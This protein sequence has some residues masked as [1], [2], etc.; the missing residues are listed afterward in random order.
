MAEGVLLMSVK[1]RDRVFLV[2]QTV[3]GRLGQRE[4]SERLGVN[5]RKF[6]RLV[7][8]WRLEGDAGLVSRHRGWSSNGRMGQE[9][10]ER[11]ADLLRDARY[12]GF[13]ASLMAETLELER[14]EVSAETI[15]QMRIALSLW[16]PKTRRARRVFQP[17]ERRPRFGE[18]IQVDGSP[19]DW[20][21]GRGPRCT[22]IVFIDD[23][24]NRLT[25]LRFAP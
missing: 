22:L 25:A 11:I 10:R 13:G 6:K 9:R 8:A 5:V 24:T 16:K 14:I 15:R 20:F 1:E 7:R 4:A 3:E 19:H 23:A 2:R 12:E 17:R 21:E 18:L